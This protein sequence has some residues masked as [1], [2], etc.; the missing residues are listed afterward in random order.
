MYFRSFYLLFVIFPFVVSAAVPN[1]YIVEMSGEPVAV[2][3]ARRVGRGGM[4]GEMARQ[5]RLQIREEQRPVRTR[6]QAA[7]AEI[8]GSVENV[9]NAFIVNMSD[10]QAAQLESIPGVLKVHP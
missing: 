2:N 8:L 7:N 6:L 10:E 4:R 3:V 1:R 5:R 9:A